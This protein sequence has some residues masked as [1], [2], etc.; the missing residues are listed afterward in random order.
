MGGHTWGSTLANLNLNLPGGYTLGCEYF[1]DVMAGTYPTRMAMQVDNNTANE[2]AGMRYNGVAAGTRSVSV[3]GG[4]LTTVDS[5][6]INEGTL[7][8]QALA[9]GSRAHLSAAN[10]S[11]GSGSFGLA[12]PAGMTNLRLGSDSGSNQLIGGLVR[13]WIV[14]AAA[15]GGKPLTDY[16]R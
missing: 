2:R 4:T 13:A 14:P 10:G 1:A 12:V 3:T 6:A 8:K 7:V 9:V 15:Y 16:S 11:L 5:Y